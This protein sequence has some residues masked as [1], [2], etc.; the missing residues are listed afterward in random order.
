MKRMNILNIC[1]STDAFH[2]EIRHRATPP[3]TAGL[4]LLALRERWSA[5]HSTGQTGLGAGLERAAAP[6]RFGRRLTAGF[7]GLSLMLGFVG[8]SHAQNPGWTGADPFY[9]QQKPPFPVNPPLAPGGGNGWAPF[10]NGA[11]GG[12]VLP[13]NGTICFAFQNTENLEKKK[14]FRIEIQTANVNDIQCLAPDDKGAYDSAGVAFDPTKQIA[15]NGGGFR[16]GANP[17]ERYDEWI[18]KPQPAWE[19]VSYK[20]KCNRPI[21]ISSVRAWTACALVRPSF[22]S[23]LAQDITF[24]VPIPG[25]MVTNQQI[26]AI[27]VFPTTVAINPSVPPTFSAPTQSGN[28]TAMPAQ[29]DPDGNTRPLGGVVYVTDGPGLD[30]SQ[31]CA[32]SF[33]MQGPAADLQYTMYAYDSTTGEFQEYGL[34]LRPTLTLTPSRG[35]VIL[36]F[37]S[38]QGMNYDLD[39]SRDLATWQPMQSVTGTGGFISATA[40]MNSPAGFFRLRYQVATNSAGPTT[41][42]TVV[43]ATPSAAGDRVTISFSGPVDEVSADNLANYFLGNST[44]TIP[45]EAVS[46]ST[47]QSVD[48]FPDQPLGSGVAYFLGVQGVSDLLGNLMTPYT[49]TFACSVVQTPSAGGLLVKDTGAYSECNPDGFYHVVQD[50]T[51]LCPDGVERT[52]RVYDQKTTQ[53]CP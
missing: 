53:P 32:F 3:R 19:W 14:Y 42:L 26:T 7:L 23:L 33:A 18:F 1:A 37:D 47:P 34:D 36:Q 24:G 31:S 4:A 9:V 46:L 48:L 45:I 49:G 41:P 15:Y 11:G 35:S 29:V 5:A 22:N 28:W 43:S 8:D 17:N 6:P 25:A 51:Y 40:P 38:F 52:Y 20:N 10:P 16:A 27:M 44:G 13:A 2:L 50:Q 12:V 30:P 39:F 21:T